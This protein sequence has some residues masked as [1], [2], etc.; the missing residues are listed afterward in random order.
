MLI[1]ISSLYGDVQFPDLPPVRPYTYLNMAITLDGKAAVG[2]HGYLLTGSG[3]DRR[4]MDELRAVADA[5]MV[6]AG[7]IRSDD[8]PLRVRSEDLRRRRIEAGL[9]ESPL[10][11]VVTR[12]CEVSP[13][14]KAFTASA[15]AVVT[16]TAAPVERREALAKVAKV[17]IC[18][19]ESVNL[20]TA[21]SA[22]RRELGVRRLL[23]EGGPSLV[24]SLLHEML[25]D[26]LFVML[27]PLI[28]GGRDTVTLVE[29]E[30]FGNEC[31]PR[32]SLVSVREV[33]GE[34]FLRYR[35]LRPEEATADG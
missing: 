29:G 10:A 23:V 21:F 3:A 28:K 14:A 6:G 19:E 18:G 24:S 13:T 15:G 22:L 35:V 25:V 9:P 5:V 1:V 27:A 20:H 34:L 32:L 7:T 17:V 26:E 12:S 8:P 16:C 31:M 33:E 2:N 30:A 11:V 4:A